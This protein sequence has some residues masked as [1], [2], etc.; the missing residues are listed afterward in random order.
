MYMWLVVVVL[1]GMV[2]DHALSIQN[3]GIP[4]PTVISQHPGPERPPSVLAFG[5]ECISPGLRVTLKSECLGGE[6][7]WNKLGHRAG[8]SIRMNRSPLRYGAKLW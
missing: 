2:L 6:V 1:Q 4:R 3:P 5:V 7:Y 8:A